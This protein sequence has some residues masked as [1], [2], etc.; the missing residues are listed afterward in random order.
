MKTTSHLRRF[1]LVALVGFGL[2]LGLTACKSSDEGASKSEHPK[3]S[4]HPSGSEHP[5]KPEHPK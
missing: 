5:T 2:S 4:E 1:A 3:K